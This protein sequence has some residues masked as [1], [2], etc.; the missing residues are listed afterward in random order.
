[1]DLLQSCTK[2]SAWCLQIVKSSRKSYSNCPFTVVS[3]LPHIKLF[4]NCLAMPI[5][6]ENLILQYH[7]RLA[8]QIMPWSHHWN[9]NV[10]ILTK[11]SSLVA[12]EVVILTTSSAAS[13]ES[14]VKMTTFSFQWY[15]LQRV[16]GG[17]TA[18]LFPHTVQQPYVFYA[19]RTATSKFLLYGWTTRPLFIRKQHTLL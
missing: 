15:S 2:P 11:F 8:L 19:N 3:K 4:E 5:A 9:E 14:F 16:C 6:T 1:M 18:T 17:H 10:V 7:V 13:D 12:V